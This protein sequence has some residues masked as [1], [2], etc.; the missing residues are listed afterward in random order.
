[1]KVDLTRLAVDAREVA[2]KHIQ[3][4]RPGRDARDAL[5]A[6]LKREAKQAR[7]EH[8]QPDDALDTMPDLERHR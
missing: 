7:R 5:V 8:P 3:S 1:M 4:D 6:A 2:A